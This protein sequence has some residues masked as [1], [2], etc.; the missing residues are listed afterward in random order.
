MK[1]PHE[2]MAKDI[3]SGSGGKPESYETVADGVAMRL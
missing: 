1:P 3:A 2:A